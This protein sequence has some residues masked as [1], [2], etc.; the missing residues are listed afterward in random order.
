MNSYS[1]KG[2]NNIVVILK[3]LEREV[4]NYNFHL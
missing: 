4:S 3:R 2:N 1:V